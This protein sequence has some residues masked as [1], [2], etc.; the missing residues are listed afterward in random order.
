MQRR[1]F[2]N[3][4]SAVVFWP[5]AARAEQSK[6]PRIGLFLRPPRNADVDAFFAGLRD[7]GWV[8]ASIVQKRRLQGGLIAY[9]ADFFAIWRSLAGYV[10]RILKGSR[11]E[12]LPIERATEIKFAINL[13]TARALGHGI[14]P[15]L[16]AAVD[17]VIE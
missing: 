12:D 6:I 4:L 13:K 3:L 5:P 14:P 17:E 11:P 1:V 16:L 8:D 7:L 15:T 2:I 10:D 9:S